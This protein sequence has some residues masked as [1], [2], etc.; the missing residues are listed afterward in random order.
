MRM[1]GLPSYKSSPLENAIMYMR[2]MTHA[3][4]A[5]LIYVRHDPPLSSLFVE[6]WK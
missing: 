1:E 2:D 3:Y 6:K 4:E 5:K